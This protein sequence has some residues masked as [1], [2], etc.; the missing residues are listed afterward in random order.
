MVLSWNYS[1]YLKLIGG[2]GKVLGNKAIEK[3]KTLPG[4]SIVKKERNIK[5]N[6][7]K[8]I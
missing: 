3:A 5:N 1:L 6:K 2:S 4:V 7:E 8:L